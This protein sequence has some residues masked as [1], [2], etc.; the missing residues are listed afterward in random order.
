MPIDS[1]T[2]SDRRGSGERTLPADLGA[3]LTV[4]ASNP[5]GA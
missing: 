4:L 1:V 2:L 3:L 5:L